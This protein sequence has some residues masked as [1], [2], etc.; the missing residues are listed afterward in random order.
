MKASEILSRK[1]QA[2]LNNMGTTI[3]STLPTERQK[4]LDE[5][6]KSLSVEQW[7]QLASQVAAKPKLAKSIIEV[8][9]H[10]SDFAKRMV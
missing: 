4:E 1:I 6:A 2:D 8:D 9:Y 7:E 3:T 5:I 10:A